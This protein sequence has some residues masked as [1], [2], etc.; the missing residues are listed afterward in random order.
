MTIGLGYPLTIE[1]SR[2]TDEVTVN[3]KTFHITFD[4]NK[5]TQRYIHQLLQAGECYEQESTFAI[6]RALRPD[7]VFFDVGANCGWFSAVALTCGASVVAFEPDPDNCKILRENAK[8][9]EIIEAAVCETDGATKFFINMDNDG[10]HALWPC[11]IHPHNVA[12]RAASNPSR[13]VRSIRLDDVGACPHVLKIDTEGA[14]CNVLLG[15]EKVLS[16]P[17][18]RVVICERHPMGLKLLG[19]SPEEIESIM[20][21]HGFKWNK[22]ERAGIDKNE[23]CNWI[24]LR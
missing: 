20:S 4:V 3:G 18:L 23:V 6:V 12:T 10:G 19:H 21:R 15:A 5:P 13:S 14:E 24:F 9:A 8:G 7:D 2:I 22:P 16:N 11:G 1:N 17:T